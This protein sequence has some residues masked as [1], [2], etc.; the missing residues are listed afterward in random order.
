[1]TCWDG[2]EYLGNSFQQQSNAARPT[3]EAGIEHEFALERDVVNEPNAAI[4]FGGYHLI[5]HE[6]IGENDTRRVRSSQIRGARDRGNRHHCASTRTL[7][8]FPP[9]E[10]AR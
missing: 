8:R 4:S 10:T 3:K 2:G 7:N 6:V 5:D 9:N 1:M